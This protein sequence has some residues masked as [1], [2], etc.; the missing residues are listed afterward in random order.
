[1]SAVKKPPIV[2]RSVT[3]GVQRLV[4][5]IMRRRALKREQRQKEKLA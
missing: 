5:F 3:P 4:D 2:I 1:M